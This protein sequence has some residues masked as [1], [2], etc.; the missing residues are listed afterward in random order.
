MRRHRRTIWALA[1]MS[2]AA[3][4]WLLLQPGERVGT[5]ESAPAHAEPPG[6]TEPAGASEPAELAG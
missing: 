3:F 5:E 2:F 4:A 6:A 1:A